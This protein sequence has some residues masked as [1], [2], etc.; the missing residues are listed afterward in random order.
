M[1]PILSFLMADSFLCQTDLH[2]LL[3]QILI[4]FVQFFSSFAPQPGFE[5]LESPVPQLFHFHRTS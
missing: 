3:F 5:D 2:Y 1:A 4:S